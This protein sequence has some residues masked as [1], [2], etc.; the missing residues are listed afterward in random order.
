MKN[1]RSLAPISS[2]AFDKT[3][4]DRNPDKADFDIN[5]G[6]PITDAGWTA[7]QA[8]STR[9]PHLSDTEVL[10]YLLEGPEIK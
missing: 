2:R 1:Y 3:L 10:D 6:R 4:Q 7:Y 8:V 9:W 5:T